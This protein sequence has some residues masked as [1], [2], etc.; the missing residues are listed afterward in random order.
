MTKELD[1]KAHYE[2]LDSRQFQINESQVVYRNIE[3]TKI[4]DIPSD[5]LYLD[6]PTSLL[7]KYLKQLETICKDLM[8]GQPSIFLPIKIET[9]EHTKKIIRT[10]DQLKI[11]EKFCLT[12]GINGTI[13]LSTYDNKA[14][15]S[16]GV[17]GYSFSVKNKGKKIKGK[18]ALKA[19][20][21]LLKFREIKAL[22]Q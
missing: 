11:L 19:N 3:V 22:I 13:F 12:P 7:S 21:L 17:N 1:Q 15:I 4:R 6:R 16:I 20:E 8:E 2:E 14:L 10:L 9:K 18:G 5:K